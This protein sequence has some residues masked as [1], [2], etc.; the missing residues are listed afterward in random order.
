MQLNWKGIVYV[1]RRV[2]S[3]LQEPGADPVWLP[4]ISVCGGGAG[5]GAAF[6][7]RHPAGAQPSAHTLPRRW[8]E[9]LSTECIHTQTCDH[10]TQTPAQFL[11]IAAFPL[12]GLVIQLYRKI[13]S[14]CKHFYWIYKYLNI[15]HG[16]KLGLAHTKRLCQMVFMVVFVTH[17][18]FQGSVRAE[19]TKHRLVYNHWPWKWNADPSPT[20]THT[21]KVTDYHV[22]CFG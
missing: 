6:A 20:L 9:D 4:V 2:C 8:G 1:E 11:V 3:C 12:S 21:L 14:D 17:S 5:W 7:S 18:T 16:G 19:M 10:T 13:Y 22:S 15:V